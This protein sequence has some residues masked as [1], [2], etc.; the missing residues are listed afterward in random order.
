VQRP[1][2]RR[3]FAVAPDGSASREDAISAPERKLVT[4]EAVR[5]L[6]RT[7]SFPTWNEVDW[8][9]H[10][11]E[12]MTYL[13]EWQPAEFKS[14]EQFAEMT[15]PGFH[16]LWPP[17]NVRPG[18]WAVTYHASRCPTCGTQSGEVDFS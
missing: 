8:P 14:R 2:K 5:E 17:Q 4:P 6:W 3:I 1:V 10:C 18:D 9:I 15:E 13:G 12:F 11:H 7:P 16:Q